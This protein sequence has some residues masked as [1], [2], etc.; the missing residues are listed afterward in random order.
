MINSIKSI[1]NLFPQSIS[2]VIVSCLPRNCV[3]LTTGK[4]LVYKCEELRR[5]KDFKLPPPM[6]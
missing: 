6:L 4:N 3:N 2:A 1:I 5:F